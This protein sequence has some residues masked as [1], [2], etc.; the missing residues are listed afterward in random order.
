LVHYENRIKHNMK[1]L[2]AGPWVG[3]FGY[4]L[5][6]WQGYIRHVV[7]TEGFER[8]IVSSRPGSE[9]LYADYCTEFRPFSSD[10]NPCEGRFNEVGMDPGELIARVFA[11]VPYMTAI[12]PN[13]KVTNEEQIFVPYGKTAYMMGYDI[14]IHAR[15]I[16]IGQEDKMVD[17]HTSIK[18]NRNWAEEKWTAIGQLLAARQITACSIGSSNAALHV[19]G[20]VDMRDFPLDKIAS[21]LT[22]AKAIVGPSSGPIHFASLCKCP[23]IVWGTPHLEERYKN[24]WNPFGTP[25]DFLTV[26]ERWDPE[27]TTVATHILEAVDE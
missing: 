11:G 2:V 12:D 20:T 24:L 25:V 16:Q 1:T 8:V 22:S 9:Y 19:P 6:K 27:V 21:V 7:K 15:H 10:I 18:I 17:D 26:D 4:E 3:E 5:F 23:Q 14:V 13:F